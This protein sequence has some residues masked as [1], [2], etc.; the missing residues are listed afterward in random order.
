MLG[1]GSAAVRLEPQGVT[2]RQ[3]VTWS[4]GVDTTQGVTWRSGMAWRAAAAA[5]AVA[6]TVGAF[7]PASAMAAEKPDPP[8]A[9]VVRALPG[10]EKSVEHAVLDLGG[11][12]GT[13][14]P[15]INGF[16]ATIGRNE[17]A[18]LSALPG[19]A[20]VSP[21]APLT[22][23]TGP[24]TD[25]KAAAK[26]AFAADGYRPGHDQDSAYNV[27]NEIGNRSVWKHWTGAGVDV[28]L[29]DSGVTPVQGLNNPGQVINGPDLTEESQDPSVAHL[30]TY[31]HGTFMAGIIA[32][33]DAGV[34]PATSQ[35]NQDAYLG[36]APGAR[37]VSVKVADAYGATDVSQVIAGIAWV[38]QHAH[39]PGLNIRVINLSFGTDSR[40][41]Y[42][43]DPLAYA[44]E[45]AWRAGIVVVCSAGNSGANS[46]RMTMPAADPFVLAVGAV[47]MHGQPSG[48]KATIPDFSSRGDGVR[49]PDLVAPGAHAQ[50]LRVPGSFVDPTDGDTGQISERY[51]R[52]SGT[53]EAAAFVSGSVAQ[54]L[55]QR[56][57]LTP[58][59]VKGLLTSTATKL[60]VADPQ[61]QG[62]GILNMRAASGKHWTR[63]DQTFAPSTGTGSLEASR[64]SDH[65]V[66][67]D[68]PLTGEQDFL[69]NTFDSAA[70]ATAEADGTS[71]SGGNWNGHTWSGSTWDGH[72]W[73]GHTWSGHTWSGHTWSGHTWS[74]GTWDGHTW[75]GST[76]S[77][78]TWSGFMWSSGSWLSDSWSSADWS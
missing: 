77:G 67:D 63:V 19:V 13:R 15:I 56:P 43:L 44:V 35:G 57:E 14:M 29:I 32:G 70:V 23:Q 24:K 26:P 53:S 66:L 17:V 2:W 10:A 48:A 25:R 76:W 20:S 11:H 5:G 73:S 27:E 7:A 8:T 12:L 74:T 4:P 55:Q 72:T 46:G 62:A 71:W 41:S 30:D 6:V 37:I 18:Q 50:G 21:N 39:D 9:V 69:G 59:D 31:G 60:P 3:G 65:L 36:V 34:D 78:S 49:N 58:D 75:S 54:L 40:Q 51:F 52:G 45:V 1:R 22:L 47:D 42:R 61:A 64:G 68:V 38:V 16:P 33:H 28:A